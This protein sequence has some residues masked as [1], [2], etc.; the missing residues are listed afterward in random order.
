MI[1]RVEKMGL[2]EINYEPMGAISYSN[3]KRVIFTLFNPQAICHLHSRCK[4]QL[5]NGPEL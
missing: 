1:E 2:Y 5:K 4:Q 3:T